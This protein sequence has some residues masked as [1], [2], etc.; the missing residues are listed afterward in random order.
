MLPERPSIWAIF[1]V[2]KRNH[3]GKLPNAIF[4]SLPELDH[5]AGFRE[6]RLVLPHVTKFLQENRRASG[7]GVTT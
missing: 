4:F 7:H 2:M 5:A 1:V 3:S 6:S